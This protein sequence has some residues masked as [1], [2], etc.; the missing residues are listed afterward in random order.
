M[1]GQIAR[2]EGITYTYPG[3]DSPS[4]R[5]DDLDIRPGLTLVAGPSGGGCY[6]L[7]RL[8]DRL[9]A[10][11]NAGRISGSAT[12]AGLD[13]LRTPIPRLAQ[14]VGLVFQDVE[15]QSV[16]GVVER[17]IAFGLENAAMPRAEMHDLSLIHI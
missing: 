10:Q 7:P 9:A 5:S 6:T 17:E 13:P 8:F 4:L 16:Y 11:F 1:A 2:L 14:R 15:T 12:V 3:A